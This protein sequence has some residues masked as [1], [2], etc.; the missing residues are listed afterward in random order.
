MNDETPPEE[1]KA[2]KADT[3]PDEP[4]LQPIGAFRR[5][6]QRY[7]GPDGDY[8]YRR[9]TQVIG[10]DGS[11]REVQRGE[12]VDRGA[13]GITPRRIKALWFSERI[14]L[15]DSSA[16]RRSAPSIVTDNRAI[17]LEAERVQKEADDL[18]RAER[19]ARYE[20]SELRRSEEQQRKL[21]EAAVATAEARERDAAKKALDEKDR[22]ALEDR[23]TKMVAERR[24]SRA[25]T[26]KEGNS[27][28]SP[29][30]GG[31]KAAPKT[32]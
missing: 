18:V 22:V 10:A 3:K 31:T 11:R 14:E 27:Q 1:S 2:L 23:V 29:G 5:G 13:D 32:R 30:P 4:G 21:A 6:R 16:T 20:L 7:A 25:G 24:N 19:L 8:V 15:A 26:S 28:K 12:R 17:R 9:R